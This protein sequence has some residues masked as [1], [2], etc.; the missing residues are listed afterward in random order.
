MKASANYIDLIYSYLGRWKSPS[1]CGLK[2]IEKAG[3]I[4]VI[5]TE[6]Y[7]DNPGSSVTECNALLA[8][9]MCAG[10]N[11]DPQKL[12]FIEHTPDRGSKLSCYNETFFLVHF[13]WDGS[14][15]IN[16]RWE[17][18]TKAEVDNLIG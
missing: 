12:V 14:K 15:F 4:I 6:L 13:D 7:D 11:I 3:K 18:K 8:T 1:R 10:K 9:N 2:I 17:E 5:A 16:P